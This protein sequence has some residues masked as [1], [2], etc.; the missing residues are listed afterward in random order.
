MFIIESPP[1]KM[2]TLYGQLAECFDFPSP[3]FDTRGR[4]LL[5]LLRQ[6]YPDAAVEMERFLGG[7]PQ[8]VLDRQE[9]FTRTFDV[10][11][12]T[13]LDIGYVLFGDDYKRA[14][15]LSNLSREHK[16]L[17]NDCAGELADHLSNVLRLI[18]KL[19][20]SE[21][22]TE[23]VREIMVPALMLMI[24]EFDPERVEKKKDY[25]QKH[26]QTTIAPA[27]GR[28][29]AVYVHALRVLLGVLTKDFEVADRMTVFSGWS[30]RQVRGFLGLVEKELDIE[31]NANPTNSVCDA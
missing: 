7:L 12:I 24:R 9:L 14:E 23:L 30:G 29:P 8:D 13:T 27:P 11:S 20:D 3:G 31:K 18:P 26:F 2:N 5:D 4:V 25:Y 15:L 28:D 16:Q 6:D 10:Q 21:V 22:R 17:E 1:I 19:S